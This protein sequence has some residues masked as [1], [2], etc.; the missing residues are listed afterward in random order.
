VPGHLD[1]YR[2]AGSGARDR[3]FTGPD[4]PTR[5]DATIDGA[6]Q[7]TPSGWLIKGGGGAH[8]REKMVAAAANRFVVIVSSD[9]LVERLAPPIPLE[10]AGFGLESTL[11]RL[12]PT[13]LRDVGRA[14][15]A[16]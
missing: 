14:R 16:A 10:L 7:V 15:T 8:T 6:D 13:R 1:G 3:P 12:E 5:L 9:K 2:A 4:A 11:R